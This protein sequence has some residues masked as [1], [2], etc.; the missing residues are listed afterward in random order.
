MYYKAQ[1][2]FYTSDIH[3]GLTYNFLIS[4]KRTFSYDKRSKHVLTNLDA[5]SMDN[6]PVD[7]ENCSMAIKEKVSKIFVNIMFKSSTSHCL[8]GDDSKAY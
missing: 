1:S 3:Q 6:G 7:L 5:S 4:G 2:F 8:Y